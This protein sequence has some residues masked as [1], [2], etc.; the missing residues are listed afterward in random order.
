M[1]KLF[2]VGFL[3]SFI[4][5]ASA[6]EKGTVK[7][8]GYYQAVSAGKAPEMNPET[9][10]RTSSGQ[11]KNYFLYAVSSSRVYPAEIWVE[12]TRMGVTIR[13][14]TTSPVMYGDDANIGSPKKELVPKTAQRVTQL[15]LAPA[16]EG[17]DFGNRGKTLAETNEIVLVY[18]QNGKFYYSVLP[19]LTAL[20]SAVA[21]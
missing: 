5:A 19:K 21:Q 3:L 9:G 18:K 7:L 11:G 16:A 14:I 17:K 12:G 2:L 6:Q 10:L 4:I 15:I 1:K 13:T 20:D 8:Y